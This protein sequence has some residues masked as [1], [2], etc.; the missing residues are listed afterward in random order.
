MIVILGAFGR[1]GRV[2]AALSRAARGQSVRLVTRDAARS[3]VRSRT[4]GES[5]LDARPEVAVASM[6]DDVEIGRVLR[7]ARALYAI[8][9][10]DLRS[11]R[12]H[13]E[14]RAM[15]EVMARAIGRERVPR[16][17][18]LSSRAAGLGEHGQNG[19]ASDLAY[20]ER[21]VLDTNAAVSVLRA[22]YFQDNVIE[23][24][25]LA[26]RD[27]VYLD[28]F[29]RCATPIT[30]IAAVDVGTIAARSLLEPPRSEREIV[31]LLGP[32]YTPAE[33]AAAVGK[34]VGRRLSVRTVPVQSRE[35]L[36]RQWLSPEAARAMVETFACLGSG[37][38]VAS[39]DR[40]E[41]GQTRLDQ[42]LGGALAG[43]APA[44]TALE[45]AP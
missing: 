23:A 4:A 5:R 42:V 6:L 21:L 30:T 24:L 15:A 1:T 26:Q 44:S 36:L 11:M 43:T 13:A 28:F 2:V 31:E 7:G 22:G 16:V 19:V 41:L 12:F 39:G 10:D 35:E 18:L 3:A 38:V 33:I 20:F 17:V 40:V 29:A 8:L 25:P 14:R 32:A 45:V 27:G 9:P 37:R 34:A